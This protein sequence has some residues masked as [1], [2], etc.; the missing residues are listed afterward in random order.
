MRTNIWSAGAILALILSACGDRA[1][2]TPRS[3]SAEI[4]TIVISPDSEAAAASVAGL[5]A[6]GRPAIPR[7]DESI[8]R[9]EDVLQQNKDLG[10]ES[11]AMRRASRESDEVLAQRRQIEQIL[12]LLRRARRAIGD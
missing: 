2:R 4:Y 10:A 1:P 8:A 7:L 12:A 5:V 11:A 3:A 6:L 9:W